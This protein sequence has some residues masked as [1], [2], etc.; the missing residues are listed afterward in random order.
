MG[1]ENEYDVSEC[2]FLLIINNSRFSS[3]DSSQRGRPHLG[4]RIKP[5]LHRRPGVVVVHA[6]RE[7]VASS[8]SR[9][10]C[11]I[12]SLKI[13]GSGSVQRA[14]IVWGISWIHWG[15]G[16]GLDQSTNWHGSWWPSH[17]TASVT[18]SPVAIS[19]A[20][21]NAVRSVWCH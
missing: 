5:H 20:R 1:G 13:M 15:L 4:M 2:T 19:V 6:R 21:P 17:G 16:Q 12:G 9:S 10:S 8:S 14:Q 11:S 7:I 3:S 18:G